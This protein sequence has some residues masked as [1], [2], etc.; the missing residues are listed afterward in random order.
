MIDVQ[1][2]SPGYLNA[3]T[4][5]N[6]MWKE[7]GTTLPRDKTYMR[8]WWDATMQYFSKNSYK[9][10]SGFIRLTEGLCILSIKEIRAYTGCGLKEAKDFYDEFQKNLEVLKEKRK[11]VIGPF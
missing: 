3:K 2:V 11:K 10:P 9:H 6:D 8:L 5:A 1:L 4:A 7:V